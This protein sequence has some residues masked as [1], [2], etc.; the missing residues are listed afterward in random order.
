[1]EPENDGQR[2][3]KIMHDYDLELSNALRKL[4]LEYDIENNPPSSEFQLL[5]NQ[6][7][8]LYQCKKRMQMA[9]ITDETLIFNLGEILEGVMN[10]IADADYGYSYDKITASYVEIY[11]GNHRFKVS[12]VDGGKVELT[13][14]Y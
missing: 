11:K 2:T 3:E 10:G 9:G 4:S 12:G 7:V 13:R 8:G 6:T 14:M 1:M 5:Y